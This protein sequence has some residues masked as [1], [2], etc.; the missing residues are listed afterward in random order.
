MEQRFDEL[1]AAGHGKLK[2]FIEKKR[3]KNASKDRRWLPGSRREE[4]DG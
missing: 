3:A 2:K 4:D 1:K